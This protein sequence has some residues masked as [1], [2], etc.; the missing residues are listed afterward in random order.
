MRNSSRRQHGGFALVLSLWAVLV[1][2]VLAGVLDSYVSSR[3]E[4]AQAIRMRLQDELD[5]YSTRSTVLYLLGTQRFTRAGLTSDTQEPAELERTAQDL[6]IDP[7]GGEISL[8]GSAYAGL[9][10]TRF[11]LQD[12]AGLVPLNSESQQT[13]E[14][15]LLEFGTDA[16]LAS[17]LLDALAD[18]RDANE[19]ARLNGAENAE[20][21]AAG[22]PPPAN[23]DLRTAAELT[24]VLGWREWL[25]QN[26]GFRLHEWLSVTREGAFNP[27]V[28]PAQL[29][30]RLPGV[31][32]DAAR[33]I[34]EQR[35]EQP[36]RSAPDFAARSDTTLA[37]AEDEFRF[38]PSEMLQLRLWRNGAAHAEL[39]ALHLTPLSMNAPWQISSIYRVNQKQQ[40]EVHENSSP[41]FGNSTPSGF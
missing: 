35:R 33:R 23:T 27:N 39:L 11:S 2:L 36:F 12:E 25:A 30:Q 18:Y 37:M 16:T 40:D 38:F 32:A 6:R 8:D 31:D 29:L 1:V 7:V 14:S 41:L 4:Q 28:V 19:L 15:L 13:L 24:R 34:I 10:R 5:L 17:R 26:P 20:Y 22:E 9:G 21:A 3:L